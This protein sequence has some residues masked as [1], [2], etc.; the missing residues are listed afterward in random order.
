MSGDSM[1]RTN[2]IVLL[3]VMVSIALMLHIFESFIPLSGIM[4]PGAKLGLANIVT[5]I[6][7]MFFGFKEAVV[8]V[9]LRTFLG[10]LFGGGFV[11]FFYS[12]AGG[13]LSTV[14]MS[15]MYKRFDKYFSLA[16]I[17]IAG[18]VFHNIG[19]L[20]VFSIV[21]NTAGIFAYLPALLITGVMAGYFIGLVASFLERYIK[22]H[23]KWLMK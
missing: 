16:G 4:P 8:V 19:Q 21:A 5:L 7:I 15:I 18:G 17:S 10:S 11:V 13:L 2:K 3:G 14:V 12:L 9:M 1:R 22:S 6:V 20:L 23:M